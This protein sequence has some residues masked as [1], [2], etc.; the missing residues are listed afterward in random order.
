MSK[1]ILKTKSMNIFVICMSLTKYIVFKLLLT[2][3]KITSDK[4]VQM[5]IDSI[6]QQ[7]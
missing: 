1:K 5:N 6:I 4:V 2:A 3:F 7:G